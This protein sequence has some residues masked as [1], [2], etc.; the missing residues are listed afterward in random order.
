MTHA[1]HNK[2]PGTFAGDVLKLVGGTAFAQA[3]GL[4]SAPILTRLYAPDDY[5][6]LALFIS[7]TTLL[8]IVA[9]LRYEMAVMLPERDEEAANLLVACFLFAVLVSAVA[10][11]GAWWGRD[12]LVAWLNA[13]ELARYLW[14]AP[15]MILMTG[16][17]L[18]LNYW[19]TRRRRFGSVSIAQATGS[20][21]LTSLKLGAGLAG[22][23]TG[24]SL[25]GATVAGQVVSVG[26]LGAR[27]DRNERRFIL[28]SLNGTALR[29]CISRYRKFPLVDVW[30]ALLNNASWQLPALMLA[31][32]FSQTVVGFYALAFRMIQLPMSLI[33]A[34]LGQVF[35]QRASATAGDRE[36][37]ASVTGGVFRRLVMISLFP[38][39][40]LALAGPELFAVVFGA[41]WAEAGVYAQILSLWMFTWF[42]SSPLSSL[43]LIRERQ[44]LA[45][46]VHAVIFVTR[47]ASLMA[48]GWYGSVHLALLL[49]GGSG[50]LVYGA[51]IAAVLRL[52]HVPGRAI[53][54]VVR[55]AIAYSLFPTAG[56]MV[57]KIIGTPAVWMAAGSVVFLTI[58]FALAVRSD[59]QMK[60][61]L[62]SIRKG[63]IPEKA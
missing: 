42:V 10:A 32:F 3:V 56:I 20:L 14:L 28:A 43:F 58:Y 13:P 22:Q 11:L 35:Y 23:A 59:P 37:L 48:G 61:W 26:V 51:L 62:Y 25:I 50:I 47:I 54:R 57:L 44:G 27:V 41:R 9:C 49:F 18:G 24:G 21:A 63:R 1:E 31:A 2:R 34:S 7:I 53:F 15:P 17:Y 4:L 60:D 30:G 19:T 39:I 6:I 55:G 12:V 33:G 29:R 8:G 52:G 36:R 45:L 16:A 40:I 46:M 5:G 38:S